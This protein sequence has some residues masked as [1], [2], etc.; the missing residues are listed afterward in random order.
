MK[1]QK[2]MRVVRVGGEGE[3]S[4]VRV[5]GALGT[6][7]MDENRTWEGSLERQ[8]RNAL[9]A[10]CRRWAWGWRQGKRKQLSVGEAGTG[11]S[12]F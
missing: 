9:W 1:V 6:R 4:G 2:R 11:L 8:N 5:L 7:I 12:H 10:M 3:R